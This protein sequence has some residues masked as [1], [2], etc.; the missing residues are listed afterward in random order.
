M[1]NKKVLIGP[2]AISADGGLSVCYTYTDGSQTIYRKKTRDGPATIVIP[3]KVKKEY[4]NLKKSA[5]DELK[6]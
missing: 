4:I 6:S 5:P 1:D 3:T 2:S